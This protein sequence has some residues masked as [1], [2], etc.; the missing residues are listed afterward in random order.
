MY[1]S[2]KAGSGKL[3]FYFHHKITFTISKFEIQTSYIPGFYDSDFDFCKNL[4]YT[5]NCVR[6]GFLLVPLSET[7]VYRSS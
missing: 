5:S 6:F 7:W 1:G 2:V 4:E 3:L